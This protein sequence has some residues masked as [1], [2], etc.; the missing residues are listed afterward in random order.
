MSVKDRILII[1]SIFCILC[2][3]QK[4]DLSSPAIP[5][6]PNGEATNSIPTNA[7]RFEPSIDTLTI[8]ETFP[9]EPTLWR[10]HL[11]VHTEELDDN[12][13]SIVVFLLARSEFTGVHS[14]FNETHGNDAE[15][16][17]ASYAEDGIHGWWI[18]DS[19]LAS[20]LSNRYSNDIESL[21]QWLANHTPIEAKDSKGTNVRYLCDDAEK[22][23]SFAPSTRLSTA[24][25]TVKYRLRPVKPLILTHESIASNTPTKPDAPTDDS[26]ST[27]P[28]TPSQSEKL[29]ICKYWTDDQG[30][31]HA[32]A[33]IDSTSTPGDVSIT[34]IARSAYTVAQSNI[35]YETDDYKEGQITGW[36]VPTELEAAQ[37]VSLYGARTT[38]EDYET[39]CLLTKLNPILGIPISPNDYYYC[40]GGAKRFKF[41]KSVNISDTPAS[42]RCMLRL[43]KTIKL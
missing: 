32:I 37:L 43:V 39:D 21:N 25:A 30:R 27:T 15:L 6:E 1:T 40:E 5:S 26:P 13:D 34:L 7:P 14:A 20:Y 9:V 16:L 8:S 38:K 3:C 23:F 33:L 2:G 11:V 35:A 18:P 36:R 22:T 41:A 17:T 31:K 28:D 24:G 29:D 4:V 42:A 10:N 12:A 19:N